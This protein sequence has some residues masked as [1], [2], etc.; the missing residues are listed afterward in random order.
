MKVLITGATGFLGRPLCRQLAARG[1]VIVGVARRAVHED[2][3]QT[4]IEVDFSREFDPDAWSPRLVG[5]DLVINA[6]GIFREQGR[7]TFAAL[8]VQAPEALFTACSRTGITVLQISALGADAKATTSY[9]LSKRQADD[10]LLDVCTHAVVVQP[11]L[12]FS[13]SGASSKA[14]TVLASLPLLPLPEGGNQPIQPIHLC[15]LVRAVTALVERT[16]YR[17]TRVPLVGPKAL[18]LR[19][20]LMALRAGMQLDPAPCIRIPRWLV[21]ITAYLS[22]MAPTALLTPAS[23]AMLERG[24]TADAAMT[25]HLLQAPPRDATTFLEGWQGLVARLDASLVWL[26]AVLRIAVAAVWI[27]S[28]ITSAGIYPVAESMQMLGRVGLH[29]NVAL[30]ALYGAASL[31]LALGAATLCM[32]ERR[33]LWALQISVIVAYTVIISI[34]L[35]EQWLEP[36][37]PIVKNLPMLAALWLLFELDGRRWNM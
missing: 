3:V 5:V 34:A 35:P 8:H 28:G 11:S 13:P 14:F 9:H 6:V 27:I 17:G 20:Y 18:S 31:D 1:H 30:A 24:N 23:L 29:G 36:F 15:D 32:N 21:R 4:W 7:Q 37:G 12:V 26:L 22:A 16:D 33:V 25:C 2:A 19:E 10:F